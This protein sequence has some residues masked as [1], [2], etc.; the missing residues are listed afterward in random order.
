MAG[1]RTAPRPVDRAAVW[2]EAKKTLD[3]AVLPLY[4]SRVLE[5]GNPYMMSLTL[6][7]GRIGC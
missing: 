5:I 6:F 7:R 1:V 4:D 2:K 3:S